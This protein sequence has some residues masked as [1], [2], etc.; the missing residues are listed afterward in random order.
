MGLDQPKQYLE[1]AG[2][3]I[4]AHTVRAVQRSALINTII[5]VAPAEHLERTREMVGRYGL[6]GVEAVVAGGRTRQDSVAAGLRCVADGI[7]L[8]AVHDGVRPLID[9]GLIDAC[10]SRAGETGAAMLAVPVKDTLKSVGGDLVAANLDRAG[11]WQAQT[12][13]AARLALLRRA[14]EVAAADGFTGTDEAALLEHIGVKVSVVTGAAANFK[15]TTADDLVLAEALLKKDRQGEGAVTGLRVGHGYDA[16][17]LEEGRKLVLGGVVIPFEWGL[18]GHSDADVLLHALADAMLG[19]A[20][21][22]DIGRHF[23]D[24]DPAYR[25]ISSLVLLARVVE[26][27]ASRNLRLVNG[28]IT[29][30]A[31]RPRLAPYFALMLE[32]IA[33]TVGVDSSFLN[34]KATTTEH[35]G[36]AGRGEGIAAH[37]VVCLAGGDQ[38]AGRR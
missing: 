35:M 9:P 3:P 15:V 8:V 30:I 16:H 27:L 33:E 37:A 19:A 24:R 20:G 4:L 26:K 23:P 28:D 18:A 32:N 7:E 12:P 1:L 36:F 14:F 6:T 10:L 25:G 13:Q 17:R 2:L 21:L 22:G 29:V 31:E 11:L 5:I 38:A 34:L